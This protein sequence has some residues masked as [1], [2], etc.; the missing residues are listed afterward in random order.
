MVA[1][2]RAVSAPIVIGRDHLDCGS[3]AS[4]VPRD[5][6]DARRLRRDRRL[7]AAQ[8]AGQHRV[9][10]VLGVD[11]PRRRRRHRP[12]DPRRPGHASPTAPRWPRRS[13]SGCSPT[14][15]AW[16]SSGTSTP[17]TTAPREVA[18]R[19]RRAD[20]DAGDARDVTDRFDRAVG[21]R[22]PP[23]GRDPAPAATAG[24]AWTGADLT[25]REWFAGEARPRA[26]STSTTDRNGN[27]WAWWGDPDA[28]RPGARRHRLATSTRCPTAA[29]STGRSASCRALAA[30]DVLRARGRR[31]RRA[32][33]ASSTSPT[34][35]A[36]GSA[37]PASGSRL[38]TGALDRRPGPRRCATATA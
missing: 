10:R 26:A 29:R 30:V 4:P 1:S 17:A 16:A 33:S 8:R 21:R 15:P 19:A 5:R 11:P 28:R 2:R 36:P 38:L 32:R 22:S 24:Y 35:R 7:A 34:R 18:A 14:T 3:V 23:I 27:Q 31:P 13:S 37:W 25:L 9:R 20:P 12:L 6:G